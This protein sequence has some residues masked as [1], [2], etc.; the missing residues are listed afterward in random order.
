MS[1][2]PRITFGIIVLNGEPFTRYN[3]R[4]LY[5][6]AH[7]I[8]VVEGAAPA[9]ANVATP[10]G[11]SRDGTLDTLYRFKA[12]EDPEDKVQIVTR[13]GFW[14]EKDEMS[15]AYAERATGDYLWQIDID[16]FYLPED[17]ERIINMLR[18]DPGITA[19]SFRTINFWGAPQYIV[20]SGVLHSNIGI[21]HRLFKW[22]AGYCYMTHRPPTVHNAEGIDMRSIHWVTGDQ[23]AKQRIY[24]YHYALLL[25]KQVQEKSDYYGQ[26][27]PD[28]SGGPA[29]FEQNYA[30]LSNPYRV[31]NIRHYYSWLKRY[32]GQHPPQVLKM[33]AALQDDQ[34]PFKP[35][36]QDDIEQLVDTPL[37]RIGRFGLQIFYVIHRYY[38]SIRR[39]LGYS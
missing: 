17:M 33:W 18:D 5:P 29:W 22:G 31:H 1:A 7:E 4:A 37:Y 27:F 24:L 39:R 26:K 3:L 13:D 23:L 9:A 28:I 6:F 21:Y 25:P 8:I 20:D 30:H 2:F 36:T 16:E 35:R 12:E 10:D 32:E 11:H 34:F 19:M 38:K 14:T 15:Q